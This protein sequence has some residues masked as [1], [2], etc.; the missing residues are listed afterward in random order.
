MKKITKIS[1]QQNGERYN[2]FLDEEFFC[3]ITEDTLVKLNL[4]KGMEVDEGAL[5]AIIKEESKNKCFNYAVFLLG[6]RNYFEK[7]LVD[8][9]TQKEYD[10]EAIAFTIEKLYS[11]GYIN[12][13]RLTEA[14]VR[15]KKR[16]SK[17]GPRYIANALR[18]KGVDGDMIRQALEENYDA[19]E[20][21]ENC[22]SLLWKKLDYYKRKTED[23]YTL[24]GKLYTFLAQRGYGSDVIKRA[25]E[26]V[27]LESDSE[28]EGE[29]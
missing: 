2:V 24:R 26:A 5:E 18:A 4:K 10:E 16:F 8:K 21:L 6:K 9:L 14:F 1:M 17:K 28:E 25:I 3:G 23:T 22:K 11:Y 12:Q 7:A 29:Y 13:E 15:D 19:D 27:L 20:E